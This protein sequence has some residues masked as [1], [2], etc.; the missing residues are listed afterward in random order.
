MCSDLNIVKNMFLKMVLETAV[1]KFCNICRK[2]SVMEF[3]VEEVTI[4]GV[5]IVFERST[6]PNRFPRYLRN[7]QHNYLKGRIFAWICFCK[8][9]LTL[10]WVRQGGE[11]NFTPPPKLAFLNKSKMVKAVSL[12]FCSIQ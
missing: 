7:T 9:F 10:I 5:L 3:T 1:L 6:S 8:S 11:G 12:K 4:C 2:I